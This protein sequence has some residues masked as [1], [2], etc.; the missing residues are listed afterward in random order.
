MSAASRCES[1]CCFD[2]QDYSKLTKADIFALALTVIGAS[3]AEPLPTNGD[4]WHE[5]RQGKLP[6]IPQ[7]LS[8]EF[9]GLLKVSA[10]T[11]HVKPRCC[12][13]SPPTS[14]VV[15][16]ADD[17][18]RSEPPAVSGGPHQMPGAAHRCQDERGPAPNRAQ[19]REVQERAPP[20]VSLLVRLFIPADPSGR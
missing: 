16:T 10:R 6:P 14:L 5:I 1:V 2:F 20:E 15:P 4:K 8:Q 18:P 12:S 3:G 17:P 7:V 11:E 13:T 9:L 19:R